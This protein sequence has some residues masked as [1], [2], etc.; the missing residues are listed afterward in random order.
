MGFYINPIN[1]A[2]EVDKET[3]LKQY[4]TRIPRPENFDNVPEGKC[5]L[6]FVNNILF[7][8]LGIAYDKREL[9][10]FNEHSDT[11]LK[12]Y[13]L[14]D[15]KEVVKVNDIELSDFSY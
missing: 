12:L 1:S 15:K 2:G 13:F 8:A 6:C 7:S 11:R 14:A 10:A 9:E 4:A 3:W 5:V